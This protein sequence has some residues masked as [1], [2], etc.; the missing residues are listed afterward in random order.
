M[1]VDSVLDRVVGAHFV[2][3][4]CVIKLCIALSRNFV[5]A[6]CVVN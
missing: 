5:L 6:H 3:H 4:G 1:S 2:R